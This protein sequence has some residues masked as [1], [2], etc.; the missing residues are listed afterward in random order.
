MLK[1]ANLEKIYKIEVQASKFKE[2]RGLEFD[3][4]PSWSL[5]IEAIKQ[6]KLYK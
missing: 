4:R 1:N 5:H 3:K 2:M 6:E